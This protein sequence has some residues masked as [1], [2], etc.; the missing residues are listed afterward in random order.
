MKNVNQVPKQAGKQDRQGNNRCTIWY[1]DGNSTM[2]FSKNVPYVAA[3]VLEIKIKD[4]LAK[5]DCKLNGIF[6]C[7]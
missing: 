7:K 2:L 3:R 6:L 5:H 1:K 4:F